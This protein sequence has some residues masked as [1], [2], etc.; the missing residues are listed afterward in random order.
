MQIE[1][2]EAIV[3]D[4]YTVIN[5]YT[6]FGNSGIINAVEEMI[7]MFDGTYS[8]GSSV[9]YDLISSRGPYLFK[10]YGTDFTYDANGKPVN[11]SIS[12]FSVFDSVTGVEYTRYEFLDG[13][14]LQSV[15]TEKLDDYAATQDVA[16][17]E[18]LFAYAAEHFGS[19]T[20]D[21]ISG[22]KGGI[23]TM[24]GGNG[25]DRYTITDVGDTVIE[26]NANITTG[27]N[28]TVIFL[29]ANG[30]SYTL[31][32]NVEKLLLT[33]E[34]TVAQATSGV[35][36]ALANFLL[37]NGQVNTLSGLA[38]NDE[39][40]GGSG[41]DTL[42]G[43]DGSDAYYADVLN[44]VI[45]ET[46]AVLATGGND[47]VYYSGRTGTFVLGA[48]VERLVLDSTAAVNGTGNN[49]ANTIVGNG[50][51]NIL[52]GLGG[53]DVLN[54][55]LG[56]DTMIG[57]DGNDTYY[58]NVFNEVIT[59]TNA[60][61]ATGG[62]DL[63][64]FSGTTGTF[65]LRNNVERLTLT[66]TGSTNGTGN[67]LGN[68][69]TG[70]S[71][72]NI[73]SGLGGVDVLNGGL[74]N[75]RMIGG[76]G[77]DIY[78][79]NV[80]TDIIVET[81]AVLGTGGD[82][83]VYFSGT[84][85]TFTLSA[86]V[87]RLYLTG[88][89]AVNGTGN[90]LANVLKGNA[91]A[92]TLS[93]LAGNDAI[94]GG[95]GRDTMIGGTGSDRYFADVAT[96]VIVET[97]VS[98]SIGGTDLVNFSGIVGTFILSA[99]VENLTLIGTGDT[100]GIGNLSRNTIIGNAGSNE[101]NG[102]AG[103]DTLAGGAGFDTFMF[104][105]ALSAVN[106]VDVITDFNVASDTILLDNAIFTALG[107]ATDTLNAAMFKNVTLSAVDANDR[108]IYNDTTG[109]IFYDVDG[110]GAAAAVQFALLT[111]SPTLTFNDFV[112]Y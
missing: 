71:G 49:L 72:A 91:A 97:T 64:Y 59:E 31:G 9:G 112:V 47:I 7:L 100:G 84:S 110:S 29:G 16:V 46:N 4:R 109:A 82:D 10:F 57:G 50:Q 96:D 111:A 68:T 92:N 20:D 19:S 104:D 98:P 8:S 42:I 34:V 48:N 55:G 90:A 27:G 69:I 85:G 76:D 87:E 28:D 13:S 12:S 103:N 74:G 53:A 65:T 95:L 62:N 3:A 6:D 70:N 25:S 52:S 26:T 86:N 99:N 1:N 51:V 108:I 15:W 39:L 75:D 18:S 11:G 33:D 88:A 78:Y 14:I 36:N 24:R 21:L 105:T 102:K 22:N 79:A 35:G 56:L 94:D 5:A 67:A 2:Q 93:G 43:G 89:S 32:A 17:L 58:A 41:V 80:T 106:N 44:E 23:D 38:G 61:L 40:D 81:N 60:T 30:T 37:G 107:V 66:G 45:R 77:A 63:V 54:G 73:L 83:I 101:I